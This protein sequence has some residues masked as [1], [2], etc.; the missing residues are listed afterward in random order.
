MKALRLFS[1]DDVNQQSTA[2]HRQ[3][4]PLQLVAETAPSFDDLRQHATVRRRHL[5][6]NPP[7]R[8]R[9]LLQRNKGIYLKAF[10]HAVFK[11]KKEAEILYFYLYVRGLDFGLETPENLYLNT[12]INPEENLQN[13]HDH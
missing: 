9:F 11:L 2:H 13:P 4:R 6:E 8:P 1:G 3:D 7:R 10:W 5:S 12:I